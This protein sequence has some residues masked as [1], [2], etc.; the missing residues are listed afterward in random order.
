MLRSSCIMSIFS[1]LLSV[2]EN[3]FSR[4]ILK[5]FISSSWSFTSCS[6]VSWLLLLNLRP[7]FCI[8]TA[9]YSTLTVWRSHMSECWNR[10][11]KVEK[12]D[13]LCNPVC[14]RRFAIFLRIESN[15]DNCW[16]LSLITSLFFTQSDWWKLI[17][18]LTFN[19]GQIFTLHYLT[20]VSFIMNHNFQTVFS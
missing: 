6:N 7:R 9:V 14:R 1:F 20:N 2:S 10:L 18:Q 3:I 17:K 5:V 16:G 13:G 15:S 4:L 8:I 12:T 19:Y 11:L